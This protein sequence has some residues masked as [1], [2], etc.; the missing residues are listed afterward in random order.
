MNDPTSIMQR[1]SRFAYTWDFQGPHV[2]F[3]LSPYGSD[4]LSSGDLRYLVS[5]LSELEAN[6]AAKDAETER[7]RGALGVML[8]AYSKPEIRLCCEGRECPCL[9]ATSHQEAEHFARA[10][11]QPKE[12][13]G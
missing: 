5:R 4:R 10:A 11:L 8:E 2:N 9:G 13:E 7:L 3:V 12:G 6:V 1:V